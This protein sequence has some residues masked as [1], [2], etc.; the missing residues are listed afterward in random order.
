MPTKTAA[1]AELPSWLY[2]SP[3][4]GSNS[5]WWNERVCRHLTGS[6]I[7][8][9]LARHYVGARCRAVIPLFLAGEFA[10]A[11]GQLHRDNPA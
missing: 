4:F 10:K 1:V 6:I 8:I 9:L 7:N 2:L 3:A 5:S 11:T